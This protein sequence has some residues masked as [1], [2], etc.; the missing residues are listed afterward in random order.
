MPARRSASVNSRLTS[1][2]R[3]S[4]AAKP[5]P[6]HW[7]N[8]LLSFSPTRKRLGSECAK[9]SR[10]SLGRMRLSRVWRPRQR[11]SDVKSS[12]CGRT[13]TGRRRG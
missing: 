4:G 13:V 9:L 1:W 5:M 11:K 10:L 3:T 7:V 8:A 12:G 2:K 6:R